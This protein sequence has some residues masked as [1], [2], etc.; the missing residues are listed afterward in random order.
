MASKERNNV[1]PHAAAETLRAA[2][3]DVGLVLP[4]LRVDPASP[5]LRLIELGRVR[6]DVAARLA[7]A[8]RR[9]VMRDA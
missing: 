6:S 9:G 4:S 8:I 2:L 3:S 5:T 7:E 1:D